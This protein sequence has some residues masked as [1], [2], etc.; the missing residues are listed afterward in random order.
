MINLAVS[1]R[2]GERIERKG[3]SMEY[4][5]SEGDGSKLKV[6]SDKAVVLSRIKGIIPDKE[7]LSEV[8]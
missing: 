1:D 8:L 6:P 5:S 2:G 4:V 7:I 3:L